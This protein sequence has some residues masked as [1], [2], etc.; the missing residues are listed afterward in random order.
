ML[1][2]LAAALRERSDVSA[3]PGWAGLYAHVQAGGEAAERAH[4]L[5]IALAYGDPGAFPYLRRIA[6]DRGEPRERRERALAALLRGGDPERVSLL[7]ELL[8]ED[9]LRL[10]AIRGLAAGD[11]RRAPALLLAG[12]ARYGEAERRAALDGLAARPEHARALL[13]A[14]ER[15]EL[16]AD[17]LDAFL[18]RQL[19][20][21]GDPEVDALLARLAHERPAPGGSP[22]ERASELRA[23]LGAGELARADL[24]HGRDV[25]ARTCMSCHTLFG[26]GGTLG[27][28][29]SSAT[30]VTLR[31]RDAEVLVPMDEIEEIE[32]SPLSTMPEGLLDAL[33]ADEARDLVT[34]LAS[35]VQVPRL[36]TSANAAEFFDGRNLAGWHGD[37]SLWSVESGE[38]VGRGVDLDHNSFLKS[39]LELRDFRLSLEV[40]LVRNEGNSGV[41]FRT[42]ELAGEGVR[43][44]QADI[45]EAWWGCLYE[46]EGRGMLARPPG[47]A[48][49]RLD[50]WNRYEIRAEEHHVRTWLNG[51]PC[52]DLADPEGALAGI[53]ALQVHAGGSTE[54]RF[55]SFE[56]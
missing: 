50:G 49:V 16:A 3:P 10:A 48:P 18:R 5:E 51:E 20:S 22:A 28:D 17:L 39:D 14:V 27:P 42:R 38:I 11:D 1:A 32:P 30:S 7:C 37:A 24:P 55:R 12:M 29:L 25:F 31:T 54:V 47:P 9:E 53:V 36:A 45:G 44:Y 23:R 4:A 13:L 15:G 2:E 21:L 35:P 56:L 33:S 52:I 43:G 46:E 41:Q 40:R 6:R 8:S 26:S 34:Y 19:A